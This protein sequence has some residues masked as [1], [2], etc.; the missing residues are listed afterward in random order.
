VDAGPALRDE[1][2][3]LMIDLDHFKTSTTRTD[4]CRRRW[5]CA[6]SGSC[7]TRTC[8]RST[9]SRRYG[10]EE[11]CVVLPRIGRTEAHEVAEKLR[12]RVAATPIAALPLE[13]GPLTA[14]FPWR[15]D[16]PGDATRRGLAHRARDAALYEPSAPGRDRVSV[17]APVT[18]AVGPRPVRLRT[19]DAC[20]AAAACSA[21]GRRM[22]VPGEGRRG[23][24]WHPWFARAAV[25]ALAVFCAWGTQARPT[26]PIPRTR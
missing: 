24:T 12:R 8:A 22:E 14:R 5:S 7:C 21:S 16:L 1:L 6:A 23:E 19:L 25:A 15:R 26:S 10:G 13:T 4:T 3:V 2:S 20:P 17:A 18:R 9:P 11:F